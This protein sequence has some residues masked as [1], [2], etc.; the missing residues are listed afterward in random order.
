M[1]E[2]GLEE[3]PVVVD[4]WVLDERGFDECVLLSYWLWPVWLCPELGR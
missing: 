1:D 3:C 4:E 2:R